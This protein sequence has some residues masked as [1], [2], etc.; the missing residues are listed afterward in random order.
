MKS[1]PYEGE[2]LNVCVR[3]LRLPIFEIHIS[4]MVEREPNGNCFAVYMAHRTS[5][6]PTYIRYPPTDTSKSMAGDKAP[7]GIVANS[8]L[9]AIESRGESPE[10]DVRWTSE[11]IPQ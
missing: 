8:I 7:S 4:F 10:N 6:T 9:F 11:S 2:I 3:W 5:S 1:Y